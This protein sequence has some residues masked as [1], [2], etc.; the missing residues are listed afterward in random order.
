MSHKGS[1]FGSVAKTVLV[2]LVASYAIRY[3]Q[4]RLDAMHDDRSNQD[5]EGSEA[6]DAAPAPAKAKAQ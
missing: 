5:D 2:G 3:I 1:F 6:E 4:N